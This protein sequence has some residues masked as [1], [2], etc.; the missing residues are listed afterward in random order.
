MRESVELAL[1]SGPAMIF[2]VGLPLS[3]MES[4]IAAVRDELQR[5]WG[6][7]HQVWVFGHAGDGNLHLVVAAGD[8]SVEAQQRI[9][10]CVYEP[11]AAV[12]GS[13]SAEHGIGLEKRAWL[14]IS[15]NPPRWR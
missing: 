10:R 14:G 5:E 15:R 13:V 12:S 2:D 8:G 11:L 7:R 4:Y 1:E 3:A 9:E 6:A